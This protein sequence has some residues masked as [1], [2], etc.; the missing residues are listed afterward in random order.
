MLRPGLQHTAVNQKALPTGLRLMHGA[1][2]LPTI[3]QLGG[4]A[5]QKQGIQV[6]TLKPK[7][8]SYAGELEDNHVAQSVY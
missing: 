7:Y 5:V 3:G 2:G 4:K 6:I 1:T 8:S